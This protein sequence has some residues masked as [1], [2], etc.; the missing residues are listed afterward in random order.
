MDSAEGLTKKYGLMTTHFAV[1]PGPRSNNADRKPQTRHEDTANGPPQKA[2][3]G[4]WRH[5]T[6]CSLT[7]QTD[8]N[9]KSCG[10]TR[11]QTQQR[12][13][14]DKSDTNSRRD[15]YDQSQRAGVVSR[16]DCMQTGST[17]CRLWE[18]VASMRT[19][20]QWPNYSRQRNYNQRETK[21]P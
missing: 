16:A 8:A 2:A 12:E 15:E 21:Y 20:D 1:R 6:L 7:T 13:G 3:K 14:M 18:D 19:T 17:V 11:L 5:S 4:L 10:I 9:T